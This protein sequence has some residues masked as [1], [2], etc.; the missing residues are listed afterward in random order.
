MH[1]WLIDWLIDWWDT[2]FRYE[3]SE[4]WFQSDIEEM[5]LKQDAYIW[6]MAENWYRTLKIV[7][8]EILTVILWY[9]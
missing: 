3:S 9:S 8:C 4:A 2:L 5:K 6:R 1:D 7:E